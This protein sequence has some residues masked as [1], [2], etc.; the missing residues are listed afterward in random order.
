MKNWKKGLACLLAG[1]MVL[2]LL[3]GCEGGLNLG[4]SLR[5]TGLVTEAKCQALAKDLGEELTY[6]EDLSYEAKRVADF[7]VNNTAELKEDA[8]QLVRIT[9]ADAVKITAMEKGQ[10]F[11]AL[12]AYDCILDWDDYGF[13]I[14][15]EYEDGFNPTAYFYVPKEG[16]VTKEM[17]AAA[18]GKTEIG[19]AYIMTSNG[20]YVVAMFR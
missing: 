2:A 14:S 19:A 20:T 1:V 11:D 7:L 15:Y 12:L 13:G 18:A 8:T 9:A 6:S 16:I 17:Q 10:L 5:G 4:V 3:T